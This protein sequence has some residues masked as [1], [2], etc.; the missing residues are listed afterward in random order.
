V[1]DNA[2]F[3]PVAREGGI[4]EGELLGTNI[5]DVPVLLVRLDGQIH[6]LG[7]IC[8]HQY[9][10]LAVGYMEDRC[11]VCPR[12]GSKFDVATGA[13]RTLPAIK[14]EPVYEV[15]S[16]GGVVYVAVPAEEHC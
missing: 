5:G 11:V 3:V 7:R 9:A 10:D 13:A 6:A 4:G 15:K 2:R 16:E 12:H 8:T 14:A 1:A